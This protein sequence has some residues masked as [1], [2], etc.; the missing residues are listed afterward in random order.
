MRGGSGKIQNTI[1]THLRVLMSCIQ[2]M[3]TISPPLRVS[4]R[5]QLQALLPRCPQ[6]HLSRYL[7]TDHAGRATSGK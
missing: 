7:I 6:I 5:S 3:P 2:E 1:F 4:W